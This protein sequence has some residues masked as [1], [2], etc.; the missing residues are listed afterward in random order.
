M[1]PKSGYMPE[2]DGLRGLAILAVMIF[3]ANVDAPFLKGGFLGVDVFFVLSG[4]LI[5]S[6]LV[7][8]FDR[9]GAV[10]LKTF[11]IRRLLRLGP[12]LFAL[13]IIFCAISL[14]LLSKADAQKNYVEAVI[15][16]TYLSNW[17]R[18]YSIR[19]PDFL[20]HTWSLSIEEQFYI[21]WPVLLLTLLRVL[22]KKYYVALAAAGIA[23][24]SWAT[25]A[26]LATEE[27]SI[28]RLY[29]GLDTRADALMVGCTLGVVFSP[30][31]LK[32]GA[33]KIFAKALTL[34]A[35][36]GVAAL[37]AFFFYSDWRHTGMYYWG[38][39]V[40]ELLTVV[41]IVDVSISSRSVVKK[42][43][44]MR[45]LVWVGSISYG[46]YLWHYPIYRTMVE[47]HFDG[48]AILSAGSAITFAIAIASYYLLER[49]VLRKFK[50]R[51]TTKNTKT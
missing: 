31:T 8:E 13:L 10:N 45:W 26:Y 28:E 15:A 4:F 27:A 51:F 49:P 42:L 44:A 36:V 23:L 40:I 17:A 16:L 41:I 33:R 43:F 46:L 19:P 47:L 11:Y 35:P 22:R 5:T 37:V 34:M 21:L 20:A 30:N 24:L 12:A 50:P 18:A 6:L 7:Q 32:P 3:H 38:F 29:N 9:C 48:L 25:R 39:V 2:L 14:T 1:P